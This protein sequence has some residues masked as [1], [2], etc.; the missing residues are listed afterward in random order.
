MS[1]AIEWGITVNLKSIIPRS[2]C[3]RNFRASLLFALSMLCL[4]PLTS[5]CIAGTSSTAITDKERLIA[6]Y[7]ETAFNSEAD[8][9]T[10]PKNDKSTSIS[11][12]CVALEG[13][14][15]TVLE[16]GN[17]VK[18]PWL[19]LSKSE[20]FEPSN[21]LSVIV[22]S[23]PRN[24]D[25]RLGGNIKYQMQPDQKLYEDGIKNCN[26]MTFHTGHVIDRLVV[27][28]DQTMGSAKTVSCILLELNRGIGLNVG[29]KFKLQWDTGGLL[30]TAS[31]EIFAQFMRGMARQLAIHLVKQTEPGFI[32][33]QTKDALEKLTIMNLIG[34]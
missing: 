4:F 19:A 28:V 2:H 23:D 27:F 25:Q 18:A 7:L 13:C 9:L 31:P 34:E 6:D 29:P 5:L 8:L 1:E 17:F 10:K 11:V 20:N 33:Q 12:T 22:Y 15:S 3:I 16:L 14:D 24:D 30:A 26:V 21:L 32:K